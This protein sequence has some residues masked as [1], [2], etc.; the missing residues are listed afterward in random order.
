[1]C[2]PALGQQAT[3]FALEFVL[4]GK[5]ASGIADVSKQTG[6]CFEPMAG[7]FDGRLKPE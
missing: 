2:S 7:P 6:P 3:P 4:V 5:L 1:M